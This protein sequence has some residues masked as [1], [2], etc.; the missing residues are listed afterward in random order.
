MSIWGKL[1]G[2]VAGAGLSIALPG[3]GTALAP[4]A[5]SLIGGLFDS[6]TNKSGTN[7]N[8]VSGTAISQTNDSNIS[9]NDSTGGFDV[10]NFALNTA[11]GLAPDLLNSILNKPQ[12]THPPSL[13]QQSSL[14]TANP[15]QFY[16]QRNLGNSFDMNNYFRKMQGGLF[17]DMGQAG[18]L[19]NKDIGGGLYTDILRRQGYGQY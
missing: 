13:P 4:M 18:L 3:V 7:P 16:A 14:Q 12:T 2:S 17:G 15:E 6:A 19:T 9:G 5:G 1:L 8:N 10:S 11:M